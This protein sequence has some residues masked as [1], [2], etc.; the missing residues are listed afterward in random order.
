VDV[1]STEPPPPDH[2]LLRLEGDAARRLLLTPHVAGVTRQSWTTLFR[3][4]WEN[5]ERVLLHGEPPRDR[6]Y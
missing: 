4:A 5:V 6:A 1:F 3:R 2:P